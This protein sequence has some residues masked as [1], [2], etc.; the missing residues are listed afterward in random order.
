MGNLVINYKSYK[1]VTKTLATDLDI[2]NTVIDSYITSMVQVNYHG[3]ISGK[4]AE[5]WVDLTSYI[6]YV[7]D[8]PKE[9]K[10]KLSKSI[11]SYLDDLDNAQKYK[12]DSILYD[13]SYKKDRDYTSKHFN[14]LK[15]HVESDGY[16]DNLLKKA[17]N[18]LENSWHW[19][20]SLIGHNDNSKSKNIKKAQENILQWKDITKGILRTIE[21][22]LNTVDS[23]YSAKLNNI[24]NF[25]NNMQNY[26]SKVEEILENADPNNFSVSQYKGELNGM[27][28]SLVSSYNVIV[29]SNIIIDEDVE[30]FLENEDEKFLAEAINDIHKYLL[31]LSQIELFDADFWK[32]LIYQQFNIAEGQIISSGQ[33]DELL[34]KKEL[35]E[36]FDD[37][38]S[39]E[40]YWDDSIT[41]KCLDDAKSILDEIKKDGKDLYE[42]LNSHRNPDGSLILDGRTKEAKNFLKFLDKFEK[43]GKIIDFGEKGVELIY[44]LFV[45][46][47]KNLKF[48]DAFE[49]NAQLSDEMKKAFKS[50][51]A[52]YEKDLISLV[53]QSMQVALS[54]GISVVYGLCPVSKVIGTVKSTIGIIGNI[55]GDSNSTAAQYE[56]LS[57]GWDYVNSA[58]SAFKNAYQK[59]T[60]CSK[61]SGNYKECLNDFKACFSIYKNSIIRIF[62]KMANASDGKQR[63]YYYYC[64]SQIAHL[65]LKNYNGINIMS[66][67][68]FNKVA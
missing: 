45:D 19:L 22:N 17:G 44:G 58:E 1:D 60:E 26:L 6:S 30:K 66:Y 52:T 21:I 16:D 2:L 68:E 18:A 56:L 40:Y 47:E 31:D 23:R 3:F 67:D 8:Y 24:F 51:R 27:L 35:M 20:G 14:D 54:E 53:D 41:K 33:Y 55:T 15:K 28:S 7:R 38:S 11:N 46:Y 63:E 13:Y 64:S 50:I 57:Y 59:L 42:Y 39:T 4:I 49:S 5:A 48:L 36:M 37:I 25:V 10:N 32:I 34:M 9:V 43:A 61:D 62:E 65:S 29:N 12:G